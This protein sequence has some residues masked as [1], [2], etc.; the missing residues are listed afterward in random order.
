MTAMMGRISAY[1][2]REVTWEEMMNSSLKLGP[3]S[4]EMGS[5]DIAAVPPTPGTAPA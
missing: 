1:T 2:G 3:E 5:V 4:L